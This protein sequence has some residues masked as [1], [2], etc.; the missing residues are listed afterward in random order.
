MNHE[1]SMSQQGEF[2][3]NR[4]RQ[5]LEDLN[6]IIRAN[7][8]NPIVTPAMQLDWNRARRQIQAL[9]EVGSPRLF[10]RRRLHRQ[11]EIVTDAFIDM[12]TSPFLNPTL[13]DNTGDSSIR[14]VMDTYK[15]KYFAPIVPEHTPLTSQKRVE[16]SLTSITAKVNPYG[17]ERGKG[18]LR[19]TLLP[20]ATG[21]AASVTA[22]QLLAEHVHDH[23]PVTNA[24]RA[25]FNVGG[26]V[27]S[28]GI[29][30]VGL[31]L[32]MSAGLRLIGRHNHLDMFARYSHTEGLKR[33]DHN[34][35][36]FQIPTIHSHGH[37][38]GPNP[39]ISLINLPIHIVNRVIDP[40]LNIPLK[41]GRF[42]ER[43]VE[44][45]V[46]KRIF[47]IGET[48]KTNALVRYADGEISIDDWSL[49]K[50][51]KYLKEGFRFL[52]DGTA[53]K[54]KNAHFTKKEN[55]YCTNN[56]DKIKG[57]IVSMLESI[58]NRDHQ[59]DILLKVDNQLRSNLR[60]GVAYWAGAFTLAGI[61]AVKAMLIDSLS[62]TKDGLRLTFE[63]TGNL[64]GKIGYFLNHPAMK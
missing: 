9:P 59:N 37:G 60:T 3:A 17:K 12:N 46:L 58:P 16:N 10:R 62:N 48:G 49:G 34:K 1:V 8:T 56:E 29:A 51:Q 6:A 55:E 7:Q 38:H 61:G 30:T 20:I 24:A 63:K 64:L 53:L 54:A 27:W 28:T 33:D 47:R 18:F 5:A 41:V 32:G 15:N 23:R 11:N 26:G 19:G 42:A 40:A 2:L 14:D 39:L 36:K 31:S 43:G 57:A 52:R 25:I 4:K 13:Y 44:R 22:S 21:L 50:K 35:I 45:A